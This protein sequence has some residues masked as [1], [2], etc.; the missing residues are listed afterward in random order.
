LSTEFLRIHT[1]KYLPTLCIFLK[2]WSYLHIWIKIQK[3][4][5][6]VCN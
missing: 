3:L 5:S 2:L 6:Y 4:Y 1:K